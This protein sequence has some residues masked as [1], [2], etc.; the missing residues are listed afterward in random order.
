MEWKYT[1]EKTWKQLYYITSGSGS[2]AVETITVT[3]VTDYEFNDTTGTI[4]IIELQEVVV[5]KGN[6]QEPDITL[7]GFRITGWAYYDEYEDDYLLWK[8]KYYYLT[9]NIT[10]FAIYEPV[11]TVT[12]VSDNGD[13]LHS[14]EVIYGDKVEFPEIELGEG[15]S[16]SYYING[17][18]VN[19]NFEFYYS[20]DVVIEVR[21]F[22]SGY[23]DDGKNYTYNTYEN[24][25]P[26]NWNELTYQDAND[27]TLIEYIN[28]SFFAYDY[29]Y[30][31]DGEIVSGGFETQ[32][33][34]ATKLEDVTDLYAGQ[35]AIPADATDSYA[36][37]ITLRDDLMWDDGTPITAEDFV[38]TMQQQL[39]PLFQNYRADSFYND[40]ISIHNAKDYLSQGT[41][42][43]VTARDFYETWETAKDDTSLFFTLDKSSTVGAWIADVYGS[44]LFSNTP[45]WVLSALGCAAT[46]E[47]M[48]LLEGK[49]WA[50]IS[51][52]ATLTAIWENTL[53]F[54]KSLPDEELD[55]FAKEYT[56]PEVKWEEVGMFV[57]DSV[58]EIVLVVDYPLTLL[59]ENGNLDYKTVYDFGGRLPLVKKDLYEACKQAPQEGSDLWTTNYCTSVETSASWGP[60][61]LTYFQADKQYILEKNEYWYGWNM[62]EYDGQYMT[63][64]IVCDQVAD[65]DSAWLLF[66]QGMIDSVSID[67]KVAD[68]YKYSEQAVFTPDDYV[69]SLQLQ[70]DYEALKS[71]ETYGY[72]K[73]LLAQTDFRKALS[74]AI[75]RT[76]YNNICTLAS[77]AG[78]GLFNSMHYYDIANGGV[79][80]NTDVAKQVLCDVYGVDV[81]KYDSLDAAY[82]AITGYDI[83]Q[84]RKLVNKAVNAAIKSG[85]YNGTDIVKLTFGTGS[86]TEATTRSFEY[87]KKAW[88]EMV[89]GTK[90]EGKLE[91]ELVDKGAAWANDFRAGGYDVC[92]GGWSGAAWDPGYFLLAYLSPDYMYSSAWDTSS[93]IMEFDIDPYKE[94]KEAY[95]L[96]DWYNILNGLHSDY[97]W[98]VGMVEDETRLTLIAALE[99]EILSVYYTVPLQNYH[100][101]TL[102]S[103]KWEYASRDY[104]IFMGY[105]GLRYMTYKYTDEEWAKF[106][107]D[108]N[109]SIDYTK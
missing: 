58:Y 82:E 56:Y 28:G 89:V 68:K 40:L 83:F 49:T 17:K 41:F 57:G 11:Y 42:G 23:E 22:K 30:D 66:Q 12:F 92:M 88:T 47:E 71:R 32:Y 102:I 34:A 109:Y 93:V 38:Y 64:K 29:Q 60:Y 51:A 55:F 67:T 6:I 52:D 4:D 63:D 43:K 45:A 33:S 50:E 81:T 48:L 31:A 13:E 105:G 2:S 24:L 85:D 46:E 78:Y 94:G 91:L 99:K 98:A 18:K 21:I 84:A 7:D 9:D 70:S 5:P 59:D 103:Y 20:H 27:S 65:W 107:A 1:D 74:L 26:T 104:N 86:I 95:S 80:R 14:L 36:Y 44:Y 54:W 3:F 72:N 79:Y 15:Y 96:L 39:D 108:N 53:A 62:E 25:I 10:L 16:A 106:C 73:T 97:N 77:K 35:Y 8:F 90:L 69:G 19:N 101:A 61:K 76:D 100:S 87:I 75:N 37:K